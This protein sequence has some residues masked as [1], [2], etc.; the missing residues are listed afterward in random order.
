MR[1]SQSGTTLYGDS[2]IPPPLPPPAEPLHPAVTAAA[3]AVDPVM[4]PT[5]E[6]GQSSQRLL[7]VANRLPVS[8]HKD[9]DGAWQFEVP[10]NPEQD[11][12]SAHPGDILGGGAPA[13]LHCIVKMR[14]NGRRRVLFSPVII[15]ESGSG[16]PE[17]HLVALVVRQSRPKG[18]LPLAQVY[19]KEAKLLELRR[20]CE[21]V[22][23]SER[24]SAQAASSA[25]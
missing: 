25:L 8:A 4:Y 6:A 3:A 11:P 21:H 20:A 18:I 24:R 14:A 9:R 15:I 10:S 16:P 19:I 23:H 17:L 12:H 13:S 22:Q 2:L 7:V 5:L 1:K